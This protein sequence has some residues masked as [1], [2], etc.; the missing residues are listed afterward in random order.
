LRFLEWFLQDYSPRRGGGTLLGAFAE[1][2]VGLSPQEEHLLLASLLVPVRPYEVT[3]TSGGWV[4]VTDLLTGGQ[5]AVGPFG[6]PGPWIRSDLLICRLLPVGRLIRPGGSLLLLPA[7]CREE[8]LAYL[9]VTY[10]VARPAR[11]LSLEDFLDGSPHLYHHFFLL[12]GRTLGGRAEETLRRAAFSPGRLTYRGEETSRVRAALDRQL[13]LE[14][15]E[16]TGGEVRYAWIDRDRALTRASVLVR[17]LEV[18]VSAD[19]QEDLAA[20]KD[21]LDTCLR[22]LIQPTGEQ[23]DEAAAFLRNEATPRRPG[24]PGTAFLMRILD[25]WAD[26]PSPLLDDRTPR[27]AVKSRTGRQQV[28]TLLLDVERDM[29]RQKRLGRAWANVTPLRE[30]LHLLPVASRSLAG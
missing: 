12:R 14:R 24:V 23:A 11:H 26:T 7:A 30:E 19:T 20:A 1:A 5:Q 28:A 17:P 6:L 21:F 2:A 9:R 27:D 3:D 15:D 29:A 10:Q 8:L 18:Q 4:I 16:V 22:G 13:E 25:G